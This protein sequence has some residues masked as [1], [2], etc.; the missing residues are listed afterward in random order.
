MPLFRS[1]TIATI[2]FALDRISKWI[3][4]EMMELERFH[5]L[6]V[7]P[8]YINFVM[9][10]NEG[11]NFGLFGDDSN[12][13]RYLLIGLAFA[14]V[15]G[16]TFWVRNK[17]GWLV[18]FSVGAIIGGAMGNVLDRVL[19]G[20]VADFLNVTCCGFNNPFAFNI[21]DIGIFLGAFTLILFADP[22]N[23]KA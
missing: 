2:V 20:A 5:Y 18:P 7:V 10:W 17:P 23:K 3:V 19:Y 14:I 21:A 13:T 12:F 22:K 1:M 4:I 15:V 11:I 9:A 16:L 6:E 8:G